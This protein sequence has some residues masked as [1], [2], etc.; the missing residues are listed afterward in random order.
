MMLMMMLSLLPNFC[1][2]FSRVSVVGDVAFVVLETHSPP[3]DFVR[4]VVS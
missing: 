2:G 1:H 3:I 4:F